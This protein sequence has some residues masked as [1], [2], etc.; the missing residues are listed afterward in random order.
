MVL[1][2]KWSRHLHQRLQVSFY[3]PK[4][5]N[6]FKN[7]I[8]LLSELI[9]SQK[10]SHSR[11]ALNSIF[12]FVFHCVLSQSVM[13]LFHFLFHLF[14][15]LG[16]HGRSWTDSGIPRQVSDPQVELRKDYLK[17]HSIYV[18]RCPRVEIP[19]KYDQIKYE[20]CTSPRSTLSDKISADKIAE[21]LTCCRKFCPP[22]IFVR[23]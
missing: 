3:Y 12:A 22:K 2:L 19:P 18:T 15:K 13:P 10:P 6:P 11:F 21:N 9:Q 23:R 8:S 14:S 1:R 20:R 4:W 5:V 7:G 17:Y 16:H